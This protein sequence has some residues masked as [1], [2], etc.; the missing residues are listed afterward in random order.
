MIKKISIFFC[1]GFGIG[2]LSTMPGTFASLAVLPLIWLIKLNYPIQILVYGI[3]VYY[4]LSYFFLKIM[5]KNS[6]NKDPN[7]VV[8]D[9]YIGQSIALISCEQKLIDYAVSFFLFRVLDIKKP[10]PVN[11]FDNKKTI[12]G[13]LL[14]DV[15]AGLIVNLLFIIYYGI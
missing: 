3:L 13:V 9:E 8:C 6:K 10:F 4:F 7:H 15:T 11:Y 12:S 2:R 5:L 14:D 1:T